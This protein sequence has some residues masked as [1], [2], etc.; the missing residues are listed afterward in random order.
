MRKSVGGTTRT[1]PAAKAGTSVQCFSTNGT[2]LLQRWAMPPPPAGADRW[3]EV[4]KG[5]AHTGV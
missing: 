3:V 2:E 5:I 4:Y 1:H